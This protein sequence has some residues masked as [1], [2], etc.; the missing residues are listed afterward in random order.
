[1]HF[2]A[3]AYLHEHRRD[4]LIE[5]WLVLE[6]D[7]ATHTGRQRDLDNAQDWALSINGLD[8]IR[9]GYHQVFA[10]WPDVQ[11]AIMQ[12]L[13]QGRPVTLAGDRSPIRSGYKKRPA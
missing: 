9:V 1:M 12:L 8:R 13:S 3:Q 11:A 2:V 10:C 7:G 4:F 5:G 6:I